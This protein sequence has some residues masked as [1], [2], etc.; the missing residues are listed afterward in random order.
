MCYQTIG[1]DCTAMSSNVLQP[2][3]GLFAFELQTSTSLIELQNLKFKKTEFYDNFTSC[4]QQD[5]SNSK[6]RLALSHH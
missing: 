1:G 6:L 2:W 3:L 5:F 4:M